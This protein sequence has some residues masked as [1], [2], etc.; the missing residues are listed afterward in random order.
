MSMILTLT[1][2]SAADIARM[3]T[4]EAVNSFL[5]SARPR[6]PELDAAREA[7][8]KALAAQGIQVSAP[9]APPETF[10]FDTYAFIEIFN[11][12]KM[13]HA[14]HF[15]LAGQSDDGALPQASLLVAGTPLPG[16]I[17]Y[18]PA[19]AISPAQTLTFSQYLDGLSRD[20]FLDRLDLEAMETNGI[21]PD[22]WDEER[23]DLQ[24]EIGAYFDHLRGYCRKCADQG[25]GMIRAI[26]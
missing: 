9:P 6:R 8:I 1:R 13:W 5:A 18:G 22:I 12:Q 11:A 23:A 10:G 15:L 26:S 4:P 20:E 21:Y 25:L 3:T 24:A 19:V 16:D 14:L 2:V 17:G 7:R